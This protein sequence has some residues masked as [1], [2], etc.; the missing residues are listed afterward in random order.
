MPQAAYG[1]LLTCREERRSDHSK[2]AVSDLQH[3]TEIQDEDLV[4]QNS[5]RR[6]NDTH[7]KNCSGLSNLERQSDVLWSTWYV[8]GN[9]CDIAT[10]AFKSA[11]QGP[12]W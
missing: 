12:T 1:T 5:T 11:E 2:R 9:N 4:K 6:M 3:L 7:L 8:N 10:Q